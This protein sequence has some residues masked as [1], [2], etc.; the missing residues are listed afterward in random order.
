MI[1]TIY[2]NPKC[3]KSRA[4]LALLE[5][6]GIHPRIV[7]YLDEPPTATELARILDGLGIEPRDLMRHDEPEYAELNLDNPA[8]G[9]AALIAA[10]ASHPRLIQRPIIIANGKVIVGRPP[11]R[12][13][14]F[15]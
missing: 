12:V 10:M 2:H 14:E 13:L 1:P 15:V 6:R 5:S 11:E 9:R 3:S 8:L 7:H 4:A